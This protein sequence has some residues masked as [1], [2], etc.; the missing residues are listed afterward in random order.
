MDYFDI[1]VYSRKITTSSPQAQIWFD[2]GLVW[3]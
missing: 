3:T 1:D 2:R